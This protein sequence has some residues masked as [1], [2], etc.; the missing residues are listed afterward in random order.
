MA[1][2]ETFADKALGAIDGIGGLVQPCP[3][4]G[5]LGVE[6]RTAEGRAYVHSEFSELLA[7]GLLTVPVEA[8]PLDPLPFDVHRP[9][10]I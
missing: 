6:R 8:C 1:Q 3:R 7:D 10:V 2:V 5:R 9:D 4:C